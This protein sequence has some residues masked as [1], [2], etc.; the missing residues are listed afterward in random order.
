MEL[1]IIQFQNYIDTAWDSAVKMWRG[2]IMQGPV[3]FTYAP[4]AM[5]LLVADGEVGPHKSDGSEARAAALKTID[6]LRPIGIIY[7]HDVWTNHDTRTRPSLD[8]NRVD[9]LVFLAIGPSGYHDT[10][11]AELKDGKLQEH[12]ENVGCFQGFELAARFVMGEVC[13]ALSPQNATHRVEIL[14][15]NSGWQP[16]GVATA[17]D[18]PKTVARKLLNGPGSPFH[19]SENVRKGGGRFQGWSHGKLITSTLA[20]SI[21][22]IPLAELGN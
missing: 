5:Y 21:R 19:R 1:D 18:T 8:P 16:V 2:N 4:D 11:I 10:R 7:A 13:A 20:S 22:L 15:G 17:Q 14:L 6:R 9:T 3:L 12:R